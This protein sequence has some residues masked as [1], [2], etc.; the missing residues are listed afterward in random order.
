MA[1]CE[2]SRRVVIERGGVA[3]LMSVDP[4]SLGV[5]RWISCLFV[6]FASQFHWFYCF[7]VR[8]PSKYGRFI[9]RK[10]I[11]FL[12]V[13]SQSD[14][15]AMVLA[16]DSGLFFCA[17]VWS[18]LCQG[19]ASQR[20]QEMSVPQSEIC[21]DGFVDLQLVFGTAQRRRNGLLRKLPA[22]VHSACVQVGSW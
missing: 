5:L 7:S 18:H 14:S 16:H 4:V 2:I 3:I 8:W 15:G 20:H 10:E 21:P 11:Y 22:T 13:I 12:R 9:P 17:K 19:F 1:T 6:K